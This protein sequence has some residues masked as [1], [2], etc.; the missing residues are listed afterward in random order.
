MADV[1]G[2]GLLTA[3]NLRFNFLIFIIICASTVPH[4]RPRSYSEDK[5]RQGFSP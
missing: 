1:S 3:T 4:R 5:T 2:C